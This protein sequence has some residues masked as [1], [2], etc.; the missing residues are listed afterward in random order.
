MSTNKS[1]QTPETRA[2]ALSNTVQQLTRQYGESA[3]TIGSHTYHQVRAISTGFS[4][5][6][7]A[8]GI[9]GLPAGRIVEVYGEPDAGKT[10]L[11]IHLARQVPTALY[12]DADHGITPT[13]GAG[14]Y[15]VASAPGS[16]RPLCQLIICQPALR[17]CGLFYLT[18][19]AG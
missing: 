12:I 14:L 15:I 13:Q 7:S 11:A 17:E 4:G 18:Q 16:P 8:I 9:G 6:D 5:L 10:A 3:I 1:Y 19:I 2:K